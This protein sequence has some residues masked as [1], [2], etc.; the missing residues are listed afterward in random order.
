MSDK[1][2]SASYP[3]SLKIDHPERDLNR[4]TSVFRVVPI[5]PVAIILVLV[6]GPGWDSAK[7]AWRFPF[8]VD[9]IVFL[10]IVLMLLFRWKYPRWWFDWNL[11]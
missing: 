8:A 4:L 10:P 11:H 1:N 6:C 2:A 9:G 5:V 7:D 3:V